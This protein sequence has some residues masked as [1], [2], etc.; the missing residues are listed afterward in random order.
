[1][2]FS[3]GRLR[4]L[5]R[6]AKTLMDFILPFSVRQPSGATAAVIY[7]KEFTPSFNLFA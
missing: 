5:E 3:A 4:N 6:R 1:M 2:D 7:T